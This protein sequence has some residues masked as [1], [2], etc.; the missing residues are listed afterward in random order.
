MK[1]DNI[2]SGVPRPYSSTN[3]PTPRKVFERIVSPFQ[4]WESV[5]VVAIFSTIYI[6]YLVMV[7]NKEFSTTLL[8]IGGIMATLSI[9]VGIWSQSNPES[10]DIPSI[11]DVSKTV[12]YMTAASRL[13]IFTTIAGFVTIIVISIAHLSDRFFLIDD[14]TRF[15]VLLLIALAYI[16]SYIIIK[17]LCSYTSNYNKTSLS[18]PVEVSSVP[19]IVTFIGFVLA[20]GLVLFAGLIYNSYPIITLP[21][22]VTFVDSV[23]ILIAMWI[24]YVISITKF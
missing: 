22:S 19:E 21:F 11:S 15:A 16:S 9:G 24:A 20:P 18:L 6:A 2:K 1:R 5:S 3:L 14:S 7:L 17:T 12:D 10:M 8:G 23:S 4:I 13:S